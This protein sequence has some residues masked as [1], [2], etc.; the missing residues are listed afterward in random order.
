MAGVHADAQALRFAHAVENIAKVLETIAQVR[1]LAGRRLQVNH[2]AQTLGTTVHLVEALRNPYNPALLPGSHVRARMHHQIGNA[3]RLAPLDL[4]RQRLD[5]FLPQPAIRA[6]QVDQIRRVGDRIGDPRLRERRS[7]R[8][9]VFIANRG[10]VPLVV[11]LGKKLHGLEP[12]RVGR[13]DRPV[14][15]PRD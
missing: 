10:R 13:P 1:P 6:R 5:R 9:H 3:Q 14:A 8:R 4:H 11:V 15:A 2:H 12:N 7:K